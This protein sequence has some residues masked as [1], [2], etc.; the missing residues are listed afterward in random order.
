V[1]EQSKLQDAKAI[2]ILQQA[3]QHVSA[4]HTTLVAAQQDKR[5]A[6]PCSLVGGVAS[7]LE[8]YLRDSMR[9]SLRPPCLTP[10]VGAILLVRQYLKERA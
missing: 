1:I 5:Q 7:F 8:P 2:S 4:V 10:D 9:A 6:L 3:A